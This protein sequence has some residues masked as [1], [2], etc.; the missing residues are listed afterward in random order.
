MRRGHEDHAPNIAPVIEDKNLLEEAFALRIHRGLGRRMSKS[1]EPESR[2]GIGKQRPGYRSAHPVGYHHHRL[3]QRIFFFYRV[4]FLPW[5]G[6]AIRIRI[7]ARIAVEPNLVVAPE[8]WT[9][10]E[11]VQ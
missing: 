1:F 7:A 5:N 4:E 2:A 6:R 8:V 9:A 3:A 10:A 11:V